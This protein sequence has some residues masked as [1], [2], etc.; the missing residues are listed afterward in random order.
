MCALMQ[1]G[2]EQTIPFDVQQSLD[3]IMLKSID[4]FDLAFMRRDGKP[5]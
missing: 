4:E 5:H 3:G 2:E 1:L